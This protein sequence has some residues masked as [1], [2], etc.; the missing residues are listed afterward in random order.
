MKKK[1]LALLLLMVCTAPVF[2]ANW[3]QVGKNQY[4]DSSSIKHSNAYGTYTFKSKALADSIPFERHNGKDVWQVTG[5]MYIDCRDA[6]IREIS[7]SMY[8]SN[9]SLIASNKASGNQWRNIG[10][11][12]PTYDIYAY[13]CKSPIAN[14]DAR[15]YDKYHSYYYRWWN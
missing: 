4:V 14:Y 13:V 1:I 10:P 12:S 8:D 7:Y 6:Y 5:S 3:V 11:G 2:A 15:Y 9:S